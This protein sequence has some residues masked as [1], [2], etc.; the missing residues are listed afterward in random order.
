[1][2]GARRR[3]RWSWGLR[4]TAVAL[5]VAVPLAASGGAYAKAR[6]VLPAKAATWTWS[7][8]V[9]L[10]D[11]ESQSVVSGLSCP[12][13]TLCVATA[14]VN[15]KGHGNNGV[16]WTTDPSARK[17]RWHYE[18]I[19]PQVHG[20]ATLYFISG[21]ISC[22]V[23]GTH[24][25]CAIA[26]GGNIWQ[27]AHP[28][29]GWGAAAIDT[30]LLTGEACW[31]NVHCESGDDQGFILTTEGATVT[32][33]AQPIPST[34][35]GV[36]P[37][38]SCAPY[39]SGSPFCVEVVGDAQ[40]ADSTDPSGGKW[41]AGK[42]HGAQEIDSVSCATH[43]LCV[44][45][46]GASADIGVSSIP[47]AGKSWFKTIRQFAIPAKFVGDFVSGIG[48]VDCNAESLCVVSGFGAKGSFVYLSTRPTASSSSWHYYSI[49]DGSDTNAAGVACPTTKLCVVVSQEGQFVVGKRG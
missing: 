47:K 17:P 1:M 44:F 36:S 48:A 30:N 13:T 3:L 33:S 43:T 45:G 22:D 20:G 34:D 37:A 9:K 21:A 14:T 2:F 4:V 31:V 27:T 29:K 24:D 19:L 10:P 11:V 41:T 15:T 39:R 5:V 7:K 23:A 12:S 46:D 8:G 25:E 35:F 49:K 32:E 16:W 42:V 6:A 28:T 26:S 40:V 38:I 18:R